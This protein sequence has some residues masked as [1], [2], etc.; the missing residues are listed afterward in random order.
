M[1]ELSGDTHLLTEAPQVEAASSSAGLSSAEPPAVATQA[2]S[3]SARLTG[4]DTISLTQAVQAY[5]DSTLDSEEEGVADPATPGDT[6]EPPA[7]LLFSGLYHG[8]VTMAKNGMYIGIGTT[9][10][11]QNYVDTGSDPKEDSSWFD[12]MLKPLESTD[13]PSYYPMQGSN[14]GTV[15]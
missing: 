1:L 13:I 11:G 7:E 15:R 3:S 12:E 8:H 10:S 9:S 6:Y 5:C 14:W 4:S 2:T